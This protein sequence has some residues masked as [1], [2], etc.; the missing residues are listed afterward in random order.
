MES[1]PENSL[2]DRIERLG[3]LAASDARSGGLNATQVAALRYLAQAN[4]FS[5][6]PS[7]VSDYLAATRG[8]VSQTLKA[9]QQKGL[10]VEKASA[11][12]KRS[13]SYDLTPAG[14]A[15]AKAAPGLDAALNSLTPDERRRISDALNLVLETLVAAN[16]GKRFGQC[17]TCRFHRRQDTGGYCDL[18]NVPLLPEDGEKICAEQQSAN[19]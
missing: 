18:L 10:A 8:T 6:S 17:F 13:I 16:D 5:R 9:L 19:A 3:R 12:D 1:S 7:Q 2:S 4:R 11:A 15:A 14:E